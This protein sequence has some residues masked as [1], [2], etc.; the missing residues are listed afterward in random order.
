MNTWLLYTQ[1]G[2]AEF[3]KKITNDNACNIVE[4]AGKKKDQSNDTFLLHIILNTRNSK[5]QSDNILLSTAS[6]AN[7]IKT[8][9]VEE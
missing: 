2:T 7:T 8:V 6:M 5:R 9:M 3:K 1:V 4:R